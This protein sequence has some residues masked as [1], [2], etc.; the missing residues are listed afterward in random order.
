[1]KIVFIFFISFGIFIASL[2]VLSKQEEKN[3]KEI[4]SQ[5]QTKGTLKTVTIKKHILKEQ[6]TYTVYKA[7]YQFQVKQKTYICPCFY[8]INTC[9]QS[10]QIPEQVIIYYQE[11]NPKHAR[12]ES[13]L[14]QREQSKSLVPS[15]I[16]AILSF[17]VL[18]QL[19]VQ[20][21]I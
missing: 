10:T 12:I 17:F 21:L 19:F 4:P 18:I 15:I 1:M 11:N 14:S 7:T 9:D 8:E 3:E 13:E 2:I 5:F 6:E 16:I 20:P